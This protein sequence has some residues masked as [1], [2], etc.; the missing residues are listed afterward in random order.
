MLRRPVDVGLD[1]ELLQLLAER[2]GELVDRA[3]ALIAA[4]LDE[5]RDLLVRPGVQRLEGEVLEL[6]LD[7]LDTE[8]VAS[9]A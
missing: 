2:V 4:R 1:P 3:R 6:P 9:G 7:L 5:L 8:A